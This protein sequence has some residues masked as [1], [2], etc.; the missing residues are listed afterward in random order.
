VLTATLVA[1][2]SGS[3]KPA[4]KRAE[5]ATTTSTTT[6][7]TTAL[8]VATQPSCPPIPPR[9]APDPNRP[10]YALHVDVRTDESLVVGDV[11]V[12]FVPDLPV[13]RLVFR[14]WPNG[15]RTGDAGGHL[16]V[17]AVTVDGTERPSALANPTTLDVPLGATVA[18]GTALTASMPWRLRLPGPIDDRLARAGSA[19]RLGSFFPILPW[20]PGVGWALDAPT[21][22]YAEASTAPAADFTMTVTAPAGD[23]VLASGVPDGRGTW[24]ATAMR[25]VA[26]SLGQFRIATATA[27]TAAGAVPVT[28]GVDAAIAE[29]PTAYAT[30]AVRVIEADSRR[31][32]TY[33][34]P[35]YTLAIEPGLRGGVEYPSHVMQGP[36]TLGRTTSHEIGHQWFYA[37]VGND[38]G[39]D[40]FLDEALAT[41][42]EWRYEGTLATMGAAAIPADVR[43]DA[44]EAMPFWNSRE[45]E[46]YLGVYVQGAQALAALGDPDLV[47]CALRLYAAVD[48]YRIARPKD[49]IAALGAVFPGAAAAVA[50]YGIHP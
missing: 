20:E 39:R 27:E 41:W 43:G 17:G 14:L 42:A 24:T 22:A 46:Y 30:K 29:D 23:T 38:Q 4:L 35:A 25:D 50:P 26:V 2:C 19:V 12:R 16:D 37:L 3:S 21:P 15:P 40:P 9:A 48:A 28:V 32:G 47:D 33:P 1:S 18:A 49:L 13:E 11:S 34:W 44:G 31:F 6:T 45:G 7:T 5:P 36:G 8:P 10:R